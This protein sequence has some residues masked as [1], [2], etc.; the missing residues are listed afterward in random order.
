MAYS[1]G[2]FGFGTKLVLTILLALLAGFSW[3]WFERKGF[4]FDFGGG[5]EQPPKKEE[6]A[7]AKDAKKDNG[8]TPKG[9]PDPKTDPKKEDTTPAAG[10]YTDK[11]LG[12]IF[13]KIDA[14]LGQARYR[15]AWEE[16]GQIK[17][18]RLGTE[19]HRK[20]VRGYRDRVQGYLKLIAETS[21]GG[22]VLMPTMTQLEFTNGNKIV[23]RKLQE[24]RDTYHFE[25]IRGIR[26]S[27][28]KTA[29][30]A[31]K[32]L[33]SAQA[34]VQVWEALKSKAY[35]AGV[36]AVDEKVN[37]LYQYR[38]QDRPNRKVTG[39]QYFELADF[40]ATNG[41]NRL[42]TT[43]FDEALKRDPNVVSTVH[44]T[45]G[46][47]MV[48]VLFY[49]LSIDSVED[50]EYTLTK[51]LTPH[52]SDTRAY[53]ER[54]YG[55]S[56]A[57]QI[58]AAM[59]K[60][61]VKIV[62]PD[63]K[64]EDEP[65]VVKPPDKK[66]DPVRT[67]PEEKRSEPTSQPM[68]PEAPDRVKRLVAEGDKHFD[69]GMDHLLKSDPNANPDGWADENKKALGEF[70]KATASYGEAQDEYP[71]NVEVPR[72]LLDRF[73]EATMRMSLCRKRSVSSK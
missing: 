68:P 64:K 61:E 33:D 5:K 40:A 8:T 18:I 57:R 22:T 43:L 13:T 29:F 46:R 59:L 53:R 48:D 67:D 14:H 24:D 52:Y 36:E 54:L 60:Q 3:A 39:W 32:K 51:I 30:K 16:L 6:P 23:V 34:F 49:F 45:K 28:P 69:A 70:Q 21:R 1:R 42:V 11:D 58:I 47:I 17:E 71:K 7:P 9:T 19:D 25:D 66:D 10:A 44:E 4:T 55:D 12:S 62:E 27:Q 38:F 15:E 65:I 31:V 35:L 41:A 50:A 20:R 56:E 37:G 2:S 73:R 63:P 72:P 26:S